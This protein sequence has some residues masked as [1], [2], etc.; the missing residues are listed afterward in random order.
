MQIRRVKPVSQLHPSRVCS[1]LHK[2][3]SRSTQVASARFM[4]K[5]RIGTI[6]SFRPGYGALMPQ[7]ARYSKPRP[8]FQTGR[9]VSGQKAGKR[10][11][12]AKSP[13]SLK[14]R[15]RQSAANRLFRE[16]GR[17][18]RARTRDLRFWRPPLYQLSYTP[19]KSRSAGKNPRRGSALKPVPNRLAPKLQAISETGGGHFHSRRLSLL[20]TL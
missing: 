5:R 17:G 2:T 10:H 20:L 13:V 11:V 9:P 15:S 12:E 6:Q 18:S 7:H 1:S 4:P 3:D 8:L 16:T 19:R 14:R